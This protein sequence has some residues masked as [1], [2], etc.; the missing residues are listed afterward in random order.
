MCLRCSGSR[1]P[2]MP[3]L[4]RRRTGAGRVVRR[5]RASMPCGR[6]S[7]SWQPS[8]AGALPLANGCATCPSLRQQPARRW[9]RAPLTCRA[10][11]TWCAEPA[12]CFSSR[13]LTPPPPPASRASLRMWHRWSSPPATHRPT[14]SHPAW[15]PTFSVRWPLG[16]ASSTLQTFSRCTSSSLTRRRSTTWSGNTQRPTISRRSRT[17]LWPSWSAAAC[18]CTAT[19]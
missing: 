2:T 12:R 6:K 19:T 13:A 3:T 8:N 11:V 5:H 1:W 16:T 15:H 7:R 14:D 10:S 17:R 18:C 4:R 9:C